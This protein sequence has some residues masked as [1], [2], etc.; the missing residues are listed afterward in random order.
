MTILDPLESLVLR[1]NRAQLNRDKHCVPLKHYRALEIL[2]K[3]DSITKL[4]RAMR[5]K[6]I[7][8]SLTYLISK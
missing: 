3:T 7:N 5:H 1:F 8:V 6:S 2:N 4:Q